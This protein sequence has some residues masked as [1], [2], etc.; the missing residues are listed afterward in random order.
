MNLLMPYALLSAIFK[1]D[2]NRVSV[3]GNMFCQT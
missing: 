3:G 1:L 2:A